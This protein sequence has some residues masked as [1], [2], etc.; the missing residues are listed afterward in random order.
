MIK[1]AQPILF[2]LMLLFFCQTNSFGQSNLAQTTSSGLT[3]SF[4]GKFITRPF[5]QC[6]KAHSPDGNFWCHYDIGNVSDE[7]R[8]LVNFRFYDKDQLLFELPIAPGSDLYI[9]NA[10]F[11]VFLD[12]KFHFKKELIIY[13]YDKNG[14]QLFSQIVDGA[15]L[16]DFSNS[17]D[18][19]GLGTGKN[20]YIFSLK[21]RTRKTYETCDQFDISD[22]GNLVA[23]A[24]GESLNIFSEGQL[25]KHLKTGFLYPRQIKLSQSHDLVAVIDK[26]KLLAFAV[27]SGELLFAK[28][29]EPQFSFRDLF[30]ADGKIYAGVHRRHNGSSRGLLFEYN[31]QGNLLNSEIKAEKKFKAFSHQQKLEKSQIIYDPIPW[32]FFPFDSMRTVWNYYE[33]HMS[34]GQPD[35]SYL[36]QGLDLI[37]PIAEPVYAVAAGVVK[38]V[39]TISGA[40]HWR[41]AVGEA[42]PDYSNGWLYAHLIESSIQFDVGD[43]VN[44]HDYLGDII[45]WTSAWGHIHFVQIRDSGWVW[46]YDDNEWGINFNPLLALTPAID[47]IAPKIEP[48][49]PNSKFAFCT[50]ETS[51]YLNPDSLF[52][53][54]DIIAKIVDYVGDSPWQQPAFETYYWL[55]KM[56]EA[57][58]VLPRTLGHRLNHAFEMYN[59]G[60]Y[61]P[62]ATVIYKRDQL[63]MPSSWMDEERNFYQIL[64]NNN[65]DSL[66]D[67]W[68]GGY[69]L[70]TGDYED[71]EYRIFVQAMDAY[72]NAT[73]DSLDVNFC[74][75]NVSQ[76]NTGHDR[77]EKF[78]LKQNYPNPF[79][80][81]TKITFSLPHPAQVKLTVYNLLGEQIKTLADEFKNAGSYSLEFEAKFLTGGVYFYKLES[82]ELISIKKM[83]LLP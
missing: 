42:V 2:N 78:E 7:Y 53:D 62:Y 39:L 5:S 81:L 13:F 11:I 45:E 34:Y 44:Q 28:K 72:G 18:F 76:A 15:S 64:T 9:S 43:S 3:V 73:T 25:K 51:Y 68:E 31:A 32:P 38:N 1:L 79:N 47:L 82:G 40:Y 24:L 50:N 71:G 65:G 8:E 80:P 4:N 70:V 74:N 30:L 6:S 41:L 66:I 10:G 21:E 35:W 67:V 37:V 83:M 59:T 77:N 36:H 55:K 23:T 27:S 52:G 29:L 56:P 17:G 12:N 48:V 49:F 61:E 75:G 63:L 69:S 60:Y 19:F 57:R 33:Q 58:I 46:R 20:L 54:I 22:D 14:Q 16:F 26:K